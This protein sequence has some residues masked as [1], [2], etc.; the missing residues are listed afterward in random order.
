MSAPECDLLPENSA[1]HRFL[2]TDSLK[3][4]R[5]FVTEKKK[6]LDK[7]LVLPKFQHKELIGCSTGS[8]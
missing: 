1:V 2:Q 8:G 4:R 5:E 7:E 6:E 3:E